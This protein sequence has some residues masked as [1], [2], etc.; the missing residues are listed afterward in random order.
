VPDVY[1]GDEL[2]ALALVDPDNRRPVDWSARRAALGRVRAG[3]APRDWG[4]RKLALIHRALQLRARR[5]SAFAPGA[6]YT[7]VEAPEGWLA[8]T[9]GDAEVLVAVPV[10]KA[11]PPFE[12]TGD[13]R[14]RWRGV[15]TGL[16]HDVDAIA[17]L[18]L[19]ER[20]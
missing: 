5:P 1:Q 3:E 10:R 15:L 6:A 8:F 19:F 14:G 2:E 16:E 12:P 20:P 7:P 18:A 11:P 17:D 9:R 4:E 13:L